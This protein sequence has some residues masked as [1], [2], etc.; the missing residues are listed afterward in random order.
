MP[1]RPPAT[2]S[3]VA[4]AFCLPV[5]VCAGCGG[6]EGTSFDLPTLTELG[7]NPSAQSDDEEKRNMLVVH[8]RLSAVEVPLGAISGSEEL[9]SHLQEDR[10][11]P[12]QSAG[13]SRNGLRVGVGSADAWEDIAATVSRATGRQVRQA[14]YMAI[15]HR[16][17]P[18]ILKSDQ[19]ERTVFCSRRDRTLVGQD[20]PRG[21]YL[22]MFNFA[23]DPNDLTRILVNVVPE[24]R[25]ARQHLQILRT[26]DR[27][28]MR[29]EPRRLVLDALAFQLDVRSGEYLVI[30]PNAAARRPS[31][32][33]HHLLIHDRKGV[34][35]ETILILSPEVHRT[36]ISSSRTPATSAPPAD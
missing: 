33:A 26:G 6:E 16:P 12:L 22:L 25:S 14:G 20:L 30:G 3:L 8:T 24:V 32:P 9:W 1:R 31:S 7:G 19:P 5:A 17:M 11:T 27:Y 35:F 21:E 18:V 28:R 10:A 34:E 29:H 4:L 2:P 23:L 36:E 15:P 13:L